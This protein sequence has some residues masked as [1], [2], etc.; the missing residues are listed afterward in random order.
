[1]GKCV[2]LRCLSVTF[3]SCYLPI[4][5]ASVAVCE[6]EQRIDGICWA[7][8]E[9]LEAQTLRQQAVPTPTHSPSQFPEG[10]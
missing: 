5:V 2:T 8:G 6:A 4:R 7:R 3:P 1:M 10:G 9:L